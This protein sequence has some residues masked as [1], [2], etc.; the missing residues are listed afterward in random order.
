MAVLLSPLQHNCVK[1]IDNI[2][3]VIL[4]SFVMLPRQVT[5]SVSSNQLVYK[6]IYT[7]IIRH[8][9]ACVGQ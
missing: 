1:H 3:H 8:Y 4:G 9:E 5:V 2:V 7:S 6:F